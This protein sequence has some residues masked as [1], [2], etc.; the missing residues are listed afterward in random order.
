MSEPGAPNLDVEHLRTLS[1]LYVEDEPTTRQLF[2]RFLRRRVGRV[3]EANDGE[4]GLAAFHAEHPALVI[5][6]IQMPKLDGLALAAELR[7]VDATVPIIVTTAFEQVDYL[8]K[9]IEVGID[10]Y[11]TKPVDPRK[12]EVA[13]LSCARRIR[14]EAL[15]AAE[16][17]RAIEAVRAHE[18]EA[19]GLLAGGMAHDFNNLIQ[20]ILASLELAVPMLGPD[21][22]LEELLGP[23]LDATRQARQL[24][25][26]LVTLS[27]NDF[28]RLRPGPLPSLLR[29][30]VT[31]ALAGA[32]TALSLE[33]DDALPDVKH[34]PLMIARAVSH[35][36]ENARQA[37]NDA[38]TL[39]VRAV[40]RTLA[41]GE[42]AS[43]AAG[44]YVELTFEDSGP[45]IPPDVMPRI[46]DPYFSTKPRGKTRGTGLG[47]ALCQAIV[48]Q[49]QGVL[50]ATSAPGRGASMAVLLPVATPALRV[51]GPA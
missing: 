14:G 32:S 43:L 9:S 35:L 42:M 3:I 7:Q 27:E 49:H 31:T 48:R 26:W 24:G 5:T 41:T 51:Q 4:A 45:G 16:R 47:L 8:H 11:V 19:L 50:R 33:L 34:D 20:A 46:F 6:D 28:A 30:T 37:M 18:R 38:G 23:A 10:R 15:L 13:L 25:R 17:E 12:L 36:V 29:S 44:R 21:S 22:E 1:V 2:A 40:E 39:R